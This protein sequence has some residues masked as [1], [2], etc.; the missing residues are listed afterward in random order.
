[1]NHFLKRSGT[2]K[3]S[4][5][6]LNNIF[7]SLKTSNKDK[8]SLFLEIKENFLFKLNIKN[9]N[10]ETFLSS[11]II[12]PMHKKFPRFD[13]EFNDFNHLYLFML[14]NKKDDKIIPFLGEDVN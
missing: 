12:I 2:V 14:N 5:K 7:Y 9:I 3:I 6:N 8:D 10:E 13:N 11:K 1:M 4:S